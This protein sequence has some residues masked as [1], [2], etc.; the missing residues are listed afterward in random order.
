MKRKKR[1]PIDQLVVLLAHW[2]AS[3]REN[4]GGGSCA[5]SARLLPSPWMSITSASTEEEAMLCDADEGDGKEIQSN[6]CG[7]LSLASLC[8]DIVSSGP[9]NLDN[10]IRILL[11]W[12]QIF[13]SPLSI[14]I[15]AQKLKSL[16][17]EREFFSKIKLEVKVPQATRSNW[18]STEQ[19]WTCVSQPD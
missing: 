4:I 12:L 9:T 3:K 15:V 16:P 11:P 18:T 10:L 19:P 5:T 7:T 6:L 14:S 13:S 8:V 1:R 2:E 17:K